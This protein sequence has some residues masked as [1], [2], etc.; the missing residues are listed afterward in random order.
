MVCDRRSLPAALVALQ[1]TGAV[2]ALVMFG[3]FADYVGRRTMMLWTA[4][5]V[6]TF[7]AGT[8]LAAGYARYAVARFLA[9]GSV[10]VHVVFAI[11]IP[12]ESMTHA[13][14][15]QQ[16]LFLAVLGLELCEMW[17]VTIRPLVVDWRLK[18]VIFLA[19]TA[20]LL[21]VL[22]TASESPRW[23]V[24]KGRLDEAE[25]VMME[26][27]RINN[28]PLAVTGCLVEKLK[29]QIK[30][31]ACRSSVDKEDLIDARS[32][33]RRA[34]ADYNDYTIQYLTV[35]V[36][37]AMYLVI[38]FMINGVALVTVLSACFVLAGSIQC[39]LSVAVGSG[40]STVA[41]TL[42]ILSKGVSNVVLVH[43]FTYVLE[44][45]PSAVRAGVACWAFGCGRVA[46]MCAATTLVLRPVGHEDVVFAMTGLVLFVCLLIV[47]TLPRT[48]VVEEA[49]NVARRASDSSRMSLDHMKRTLE[50]RILRKRSRAPSI[51]SLKLCMKKS[52]TSASTN[53]PGS[54]KQLA[55]A[56]L[57]TSESFDCAEAFG[58]GPF[59]RRM[60][61]LILLGMFSVNCQTLVVSLIT[62][63]VDHWCKQP[64]GLNISAADWKDIA[65]PVEA[66]GHFSRCR[67]YKRC[68]PPAELDS[69]V[70][71]RKDGSTAAGWW[72]N[73]CELSEPHNTSD[74]SD[75]PC[76][77]WDYDAS[78]AK[79]SAVS[80]W[81]MVCDRRSLPAALVALQNTGAVVALVMFGALADYVGRRTMM[82]WTAI[83]V[84]TFTAGTFLAAGYARY[85]VARFLAGGSVAVHVVFAIIIPFES[86][87]HAHRPQQVLFLA[88]LGLEL[89]EMWFV[90]IRPLV[91]DWRLKQV[92]F[93]APTALLLPVLS[94]A[95][96]SPRWLVAKGRLDEAEAVMMEAARINNFPLAVTGCL[97]E[98]LKEQIKNSACRSSVDKE[99]LIDAR[100]LRRRASAM[101][102]VC[103]SICFVF[104]VDAFSAAQ[105][106]D[107]TI[108]YLT[109]I[110]TLAM[111]LV[112]NFMINGVA[113][114]TV[115]S[116]CFVLAGSIQCVLSVAVGSGSSTV[117]KTLLILSKGV[118]NVVLVHCFTYVLELFPSAVRAGVACW[119][120]GCGRV[121][122]MCAATTLVLR[123]VGH[124]DVVFAM[125]GLV[126]FVCLLIVR[127]L[128]RTTV[129]EEARN[130]ARRA[131]DSSRMS[132]D[133][134]KRTLEQRILR[135]RSR[136]P[137]I[138]SLKL[139]MKKSKTS[140]SPNS[141]GSSK[142]SRRSNTGRVPHRHRKSNV[143]H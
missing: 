77:D 116:A 86:M 118:S 109:V 137:S 123:P 131:S 12:F 44:L 43:C 6:V 84:V 92:I 94:T 47:R 36:T 108:Q 139:C 81:T 31:S 120:F 4:I 73:R 25:A 64:G 70:D 126:L 16:V 62:G 99:D 88:V 63:D 65:I 121:A 83:A 128:P 20:L 7:T 32:L 68:K 91:V 53:S 27:A 15:P 30:N 76:D 69:S 117:A 21:P 130:V 58:H 132:L 133:H 13:H 80:T 138:E 103:F 11:I 59:Q 97:V 54:S 90:T 35:I 42:L 102:A 14:R 19:P 106:N 23:L 67:V 34:S 72:Y 24:A 113:L 17:F 111:Y 141:P 38:N 98:K 2:V 28:F 96:E 41:K 110:V 143:Q 112:I 115:L 124:E 56:D 119:A 61:L 78:T 114:V 75:A 74:T 46:A 95:S 37:L 134:M 10:A 8:F 135:K 129:V 18:Q 9:G 3:A 93:L 140:T 105:Y 33:R 40:S 26:A 142:V 100:S 71:Y 45:F 85:A 82:L 104:Y 57:R 52:K 48:T 136:A 122:A 50:Q 101:F 79:T 39:V 55:S 125:T 60:L 127:T 49:R 66:D 51:E 107:Y 22:S 1:N 29:E 87:T 5:A 89:C